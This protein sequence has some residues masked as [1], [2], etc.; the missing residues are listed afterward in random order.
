MDRQQKYN[1][2]IAGY[3]ESEHVDR[4]R[5]VDDRLTVMYEPELLRPPRFPA[6]HLGSPMTR[7]PEQAARWKELLGQSD[8]LY[9]FDLYDTA[10]RENLPESAPNVQW[11][12]ATSS[13]IGQFV[14]RMDY[15]KR[16]PNTVFT[17]ASGV[18]ARPLSEFCILSMLSLN[19]GMERL[20]RE[21]D[22]K[23]WQRYAGKD[24]EGSTV[25]IVGV[26]SSGGAT[27]QLAKA[28]GMTVVGTDVVTKTDGL[29]KFFPLERLHEML[30]LSE[31]LILCVPHTPLTEQLIGAKELALLPKGAVLINIARGAIVDQPALIEALRSGHLRGAG[32]DVFETEPLPPESP[33][34]D[35]PNV[36]VSPHSASTSDREN[37]RITDLFCENLRRFLA[38]DALRNV[39]NTEL[40]Y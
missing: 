1:V 6:D 5:Q 38:G 20:T 37:E 14:K 18:H 35:M 40:L 8:I 10:A 9:D 23:H 36:I 2:L 21:K 34:W 17:T 30:K 22:R 3:L 32:L 29:D 16:M 4:I 15:D 28:F 24:L 19:K 11:I 7:T 27:A 26:G 12:Q 13:G 39:L 31:Y 25:G 33:L